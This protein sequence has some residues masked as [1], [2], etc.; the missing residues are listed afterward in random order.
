MQWYY[1]ILYCPI[2]D[3]IKVLQYQTLHLVSYNPYTYNDI[4]HEIGIIFFKVVPK[5]YLP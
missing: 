3:V 5:Q 2:V 4:E 1:N